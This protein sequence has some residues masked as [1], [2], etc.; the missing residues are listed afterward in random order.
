MVRRTREEAEQTRQDLLDTALE[1]FS[2]QGPEQTTLKQIAA[3]AGVT[4]GAMYWH[5][6]NKDD[7]LSQL[8][9]SHT[10]PVERH[11]L[12]QCQ[13]VEQG[14]LAALE[15]FLLGSLNDIQGQ[16]KALSIYRLYYYGRARSPALVP[17]LPAIDE[18]IE[19]LRDHL[20]FFLK[21]AK[22][23]KQLKKKVDISAVSLTLLCLFTG[24][25]DVVITSPAKIDFAE[26]AKIQV[27]AQLSAISR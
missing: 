13:A 2:E 18:E 26:Q 27:K 4:H 3:Q 7:L 1:L 21:Q 22:K 15:S 24:L 12:E 11:Y 20:K 17:L 14:A 6:R 23:Q 19:H 25:L 16:P 9:Y 5:F 8:F 10:L